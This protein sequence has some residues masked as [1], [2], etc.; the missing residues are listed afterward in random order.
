MKTDKYNEFVQILNRKLKIE[1][2][3]KIIFLCV[4]SNKIIGDS[5]G[6][7]VGSKLSEKFMYNENIQNKNI[8]IVGNMLNPICRKN[9]KNTINIVNK[10]Q[11]RYLILIDS[12]VSQNECIGNIFV[13]NGN[14]IFGN[15][16]GSGI[17]A[18]GDISIKAG[19]CNDQNNAKRNFHQLQ[20]V[21]KGLINELSDIVSKGIYDVLKN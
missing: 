11:D 2:N 7:E 10:I 18:I 15:S 5:F 13:N 9:L 1:K 8:K 12:A 17:Y 3:K 19:V 14:I 20:N 4:G 21:S 6:P 16:L